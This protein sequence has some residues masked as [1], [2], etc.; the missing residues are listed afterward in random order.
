M[1][2]TFEVTFQ[3]EDVDSWVTVDAE[4]PPDAIEEALRRDPDAD[5]YTERF[6]AW[7]RDPGE[8]RTAK[9]YSVRQEIVYR[10]EAKFSG[11]E[12]VKEEETP[13]GEP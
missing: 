11:I 7:V 6:H 9:R 10:F 1:A 2:K 4:S 12:D 8:K 13:D 5:S 3:L